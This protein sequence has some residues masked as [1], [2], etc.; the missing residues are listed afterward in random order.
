MAAPANLSEYMKRIVARARRLGVSED[1]IA[2][3]IHFQQPGG[4]RHINRQ[5]LVTRMVAATSGFIL[6][7]DV[8]FELISSHEDLPIVLRQILV[9]LITSTRDQ[10]IVAFDKSRITDLDDEELKKL[11]NAAFGCMVAV[12]GFC[13]HPDNGP[14]IDSQTPYQYLAEIAEQRASEE[15]ACEEDRLIS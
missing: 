12:N 2:C 11:I 1:N 5:E 9:D 10:D 7:D 6:R 3:H 13:S 14:G 8:K 4:L 15:Q